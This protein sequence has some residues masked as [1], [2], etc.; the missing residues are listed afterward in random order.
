VSVRS[1]CE[2]ERV[3]LCEEETE[4]YHRGERAG[5]LKM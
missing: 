3:N 5:G 4:A 1:G 2:G